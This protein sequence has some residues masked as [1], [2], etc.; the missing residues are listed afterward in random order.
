MIHSSPFSTTLGGV[1][2]SQL[3][4]PQANVAA[5]VIPIAMPVAGIAPNPAVPLASAMTPQQDAILKLA[6]A[7][8]M[9]LDYCEK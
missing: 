8:K 1:G 9:N 5:G 3:P 6:E 4:R 2:S 7:T